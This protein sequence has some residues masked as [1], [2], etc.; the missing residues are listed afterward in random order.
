[1][2][3]NLVKIDSRN[4][5]TIS[6]PFGEQNSSSPLWFTMLCLLISLLCVLGNGCVIYLVK[7]RSSLRGI[8]NFFI[9]SLALADILVGLLVFPSRLACELLLSDHLL[10]RVFSE[11]FFYW[12]VYNLCGM[13]IERFIFVVLPLK[14]HIYMSKNRSMILIIFCWLIPLIN[15]ALHFTWFY[16]QSEEVKR[17]WLKNFT[18]I[19]TITMVGLPSMVLVVMYFKIFMV[20]QR[21]RKITA[22][23]ME[24]LSY[25]RP[26]SP[27]PVVSHTNSVLQ[28]LALPS[29]DNAKLKYKERYNMP[30]NSSKCE[31]RNEGIDVENVSS[32]NKLSGFG[33]ENCS[34][35]TRACCC[36]S[37]HNFSEN[38]S[39]SYK[40]EKE[41][42]G[43]VS[44]DMYD[45]S[46]PIEFNISNVSAV[47]SNDKLL[48]SS[49]ES[50]ESRF[51]NY[52]S[53]KLEC[54]NVDFDSNR[55]P[56]NSS[57]KDECNVNEE[58]AK[59][60]IELSDLSKSK[61]TK[62]LDLTNQL[63]KSQ[64]LF[65]TS[66]KQE[67][68]QSTIEEKCHG[69][70]QVDKVVQTADSSAQNDSVKRF[71]N[72][73]SN[74]KY[75]FNA[76]P[77]DSFNQSNEENPIENAGTLH[78]ATASFS[79]NKS[80]SFTPAE[81]CSSF[82][83]NETTVQKRS[84][85]RNKTKEKKEWKRKTPIIPPQ[86]RS[87][88]HTEQRGQCN[89]QTTAENKLPV[90]NKTTENRGRTRK[91]PII[92][93][94]TDKA[95]RTDNAVRCLAFYSAMQS[96]TKVSKQSIKK[97]LNHAILRRGSGA[98]VIGSVIATFLICWGVSLYASI[99][100]YFELCRVS[101]HM[102]HVQWVLLLLNSAVNPIVYAML[103]TDLRKEFMNIFHCRR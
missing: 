4:N 15:F 91:K 6:Q 32:K 41:R 35:Q 87:A 64:N 81:Q 98:S 82:H 75:D 30:L 45:N 80:E 86:G 36:T 65:K 59:P 7:T 90:D 37:N 42:Y 100:F 95:P 50:F 103:K 34:D 88:S 53:D 55:T 92:P 96:T 78:E 69:G 25:N 16:S 70:C 62:C 12:S 46:L 24:V 9:V 52:S 22:N 99:C 19:E 93:S 79:N 27:G 84:S 21:H 58:F 102:T 17:F 77:K 29:N 72:K 83:F 20:A 23:Q 26:S 57:N 28:E 2:F 8:S 94:N 63:C 56:G 85:I 97:R 89:F 5:T 10:Q 38:V 76:G 31:Q 73:Q 67:E 47:N 54:T 13:T 14:H 68:K 18:A 60:N 39:R 44:K 74:G 66:R 1:M 48:S 51:G 33:I 71:I 101:P 40:H 3:E 11:L 61:N 49:K 43:N